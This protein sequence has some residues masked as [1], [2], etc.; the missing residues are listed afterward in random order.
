M[1]AHSLTAGTGFS[2][3]GT[4]SLIT[5]QP[6]SELPQFEDHFVG[7]QPAQTVCISRWRLR[8]CLVSWLPLTIDAACLLPRRS[9]GGRD[10]LMGRRN[11]RPR[12]FRGTPESPA[13][14]LRVSKRVIYVNS[15]RVA[16]CFPADKNSCARNDGVRYE[17]AFLSGRQS[18]AITTSFVVACGPS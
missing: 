8:G 17:R 5:R 14:W 12:W 6:A 1:I 10:Y 7:L 15:E 18:R 16:Q 4:N 13:K 11:R 9:S 3:G 2:E